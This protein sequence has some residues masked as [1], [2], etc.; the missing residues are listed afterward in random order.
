MWVKERDN[1]DLNFCHKN[2]GGNIMIA[3]EWNCSLSIFDTLA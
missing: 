2:K 3:L 1:L